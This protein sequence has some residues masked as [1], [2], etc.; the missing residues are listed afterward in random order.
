MPLATKL[1]A[2]L[3]KS[4]SVLLSEAAEPLFRCMVHLLPSL[5]GGADA[6]KPGAASAEQEAMMRA[7][8]KRSEEWAS[9]RL[10]A[11]VRGTRADMHH[12]L[13]SASCG[14]LPQLQEWL[15]DSGVSHGDVQAAM[16]EEAASA[17]RETLFAKAPLQPVQHLP[18]LADRLS[19]ASHWSASRRMAATAEDMLHLWAT[20][21]SGATDTAHA[22]TSAL[23]GAQPS[24]V[25]AG[26]SARTEALM[27]AVS[28]E[29]LASRVSEAIE[30]I[31]DEDKT[32][33]TQ[34]DVMLRS[35]ALAPFAQVFPVMAR[36]AHA[37]LPRRA[38]FSRKLARTS[39]CTL[40]NAS[41]HVVCPHR[42]HSPTLGVL[43]G[44]AG[45]MGVS[46]GVPNLH[47]KP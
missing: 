31:A 5:A 2:R 22:G 20:R 19:L 41:R 43:G 11:A 46:W 30:C 33:H 28:D 42:P 18:P 17:L 26:V 14:C 32:W 3:L 9:E 8:R 24:H 27:F 39:A 13:H 15:Y 1:L 21:S 38:H 12:P 23:Q 16:A 36:L 45:A 47:P 35:R 34:E 7:L 4:E 25:P 29:F 10:H 44:S 6:G 37:S 40:S